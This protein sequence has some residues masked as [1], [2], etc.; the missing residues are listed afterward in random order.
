MTRHFRYF[1]FT[2]TDLAYN[3]HS[4]YKM[5]DTGDYYI[6]FDVYVPYL[7]DLDQWLIV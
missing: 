1:F 4:I 3:T 5:T 7:T 2:I 6:G